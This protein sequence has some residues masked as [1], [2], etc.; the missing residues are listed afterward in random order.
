MQGIVAQIASLAPRPAAFEL[1]S[2][3]LPCDWDEELDRLYPWDTRDGWWLLNPG[4]KSLAA[5]P[6]SPNADS[7]SS[8]HTKF[9]SSSSLSDST[10]L[11]LAPSYNRRSVSSRGTQNERQPGPSYVE[12]LT[13]RSFTQW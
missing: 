3:R 13:N 12:R 8:T 1:R 7:A 11:R 10:E 2:S 4:A 6:V 9:G 5:G